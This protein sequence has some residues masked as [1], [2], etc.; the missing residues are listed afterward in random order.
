[1]ARVAWPAEAVTRF[2]D[3]QFRLQH[4]HFTTHFAHADDAIVTEGGA[5]IGRLMVDRS[6]RPWRLIELAL[7][8]SVQRRGSGGALLRWLQQAAQ[9]EKAGGIDL[10]VAFDNPRAEALY[11]RLGFE[12][13]PNDSATHRRLLWTVS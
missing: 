10:H 1:M 2:L 9:T 8:P 11:R 7:M 12:E 5:A 4:R 6:G 13:A 3:D